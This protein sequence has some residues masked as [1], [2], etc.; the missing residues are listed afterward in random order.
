MILHITNG[1]YFHRFFLDNYNAKYAGD[2]IVFREAMIQG[3]TEKEVL[4]NAFISTRAKALNVDEKFYKENAKDLLDFCD[5]HKNYSQLCLW[6]GRDSFCQLNLLTLLA[7]LEKIHYQGKIS[8]YIIDDESGAI[9]E[10]NIPVLLGNYQDIY[11]KILIQRIPAPAISHFG[12]ICKQAIVL[13]YDYLSNDGALAK[14][15]LENKEKDETTLIKELL[16]KTK[17]YGL[18]DLNIIE[19]IKRVLKA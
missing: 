4:S 17:E 1:D 6:F 10:E 8:L 13:Y 15:V 16:L 2:A 12:V 11:E 3:D 19:L 14:Y 9:L 18:S 5:S 7:L